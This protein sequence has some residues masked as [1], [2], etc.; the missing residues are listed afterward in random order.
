MK[1]KA[2]IPHIFGI[3]DRVLTPISERRGQIVKIEELPMDFRGM[4]FEGMPTTRKEYTVQINLP[5]N[6][7]EVFMPITVLCRDTDLKL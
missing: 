2:A 3:H 4:Y 6:D 1:N 7:C 5:R